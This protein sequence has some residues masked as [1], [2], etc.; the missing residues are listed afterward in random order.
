MGAIRTLMAGTDGIN[1]SDL[2]QSS[3]A[4]KTYRCAMLLTDASTASV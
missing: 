4:H 3:A 2:V 1:G